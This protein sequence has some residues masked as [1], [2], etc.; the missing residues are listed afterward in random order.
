MHGGEHGPQVALE[1]GAVEGVGHLRARTEPQVVREPAPLDG[2]VVDGRRTVAEQV[3]REVARPPLVAQLGELGDGA[4]IVDHRRELQV[5]QDQRT[6]ALG[7]GGREQRRH[8]AALVRAEHHRALRPHGVEHR[9]EVL[10]ARLQRGEVRAVIG[11]PG[12]ALVEED[13]PERRR[14][15][16]VERPDARG[17]PRVDQ[18]RDVVGHEHEI[19]VAVPHHLVGDGGAAG[20][21]VRDVARLHRR[22]VPSRSPRGKAD[23]GGAPA[24]RG[25]SASRSAHG[26][27]ARP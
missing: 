11:E 20:A 5:E 14:Q 19:D 21:R 17:L 2:I 6:G 8:R 15:P 16:L 1:E 9:A 3:V 12:A 13:Q 23:A 27:R 24:R 7:V 18:V 22:I 26:G 10:H 25:T 4:R